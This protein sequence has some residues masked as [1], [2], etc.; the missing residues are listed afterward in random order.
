MS[1]LLVID[2]D[3]IILQMCKMYFASKGHEVTVAR[4]GKEGLKKWRSGSYDLVITDLMMPD[5]HGFAVIDEIKLSEKGAFTPVLLL[6]AD[7]DDPDLKKYERRRHQDDTLAKPFD[8]PVL[9][10]KINALLEGAG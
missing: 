3:P 7:K 4:D 10:K 9:E 1:H 5:V 8:I 2:D 6:T